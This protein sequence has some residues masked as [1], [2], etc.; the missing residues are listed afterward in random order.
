VIVSD[1]D[2]PGMSRGELAG[3]ARA[4]SPDTL[5][6]LMSGRSQ[7]HVKVSA[8]FAWLQKPFTFEDLTS[9]LEG[10]R[11]VESD[12]RAEADGRSKH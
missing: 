5:F 6:V 7:D 4:W 8:A 2:L 11:R 1:C 12:P 3:I 10:S 9:A